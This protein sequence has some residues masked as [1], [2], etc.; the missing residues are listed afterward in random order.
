[1][2]LNGLLASLGS[3]GVT[4]ATKNRY[5]ESAYL[6]T[7]KTEPNSKRSYKIYQRLFSSYMEKKDVENGEKTLM[8]FKRNFPRDHKTQEAMLAQIMEYYKQNNDEDMIKNYVQRIGRGEFK[9]SKNYAKKLNMLLLTMQFDDVEKLNSTG[10]KK[11]ALIGYVEIYK[12][13]R[14]SNEARK[15]AAYNIATL[16]YQLGDAER[17]YKWAI[18]SLNL[19]S[20]RDVSRFESSFLAMA[21]DVFGKRRFNE[22]ADL[23]SRLLGKVCKRRSRNKKNFFKN[24]HVIYLASGNLKQAKRIVDKGKS[25]RIPASFIREG[26]IDLIKYMASNKNWGQL[27]NRIK[28]VRNDSRIVPEIIYPM[29]LLAESLKAS[30]RLEDGRAIESEIIKFYNKSKKRKKG[31]PLEGLDVVA[32]M[33]LR[34]LRSEVTKLKSIKLTFPEKLY[35]D[36]LKKIF[37]Q[38]DR[39]TSEALKILEVGSGR[40]I[41]A[42]Y[43]SLV[44]SYEGVV[45]QIREFTP[46]GKSDRYIKSFKKSM[47]DLTKPILVKSKDFRR[48]A[49][50]QVTRSNILSLDNSYFLQSKQLPLLPEHYFSRGAVLMDRGGRR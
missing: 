42:A 25:C 3:K 30:G 41:V 44:E 11:Q 26:Q 33:K 6:A 36:S 40:G 1:M 46:P 20:N 38:L 2:A 12:S 8:A 18:E 14:S 32:D 10:E 24:A 34:T 31:I 23:N 49:I 47:V 37:T 17:T 22:A 21:T 29:S 43:R 28:K 5:L 16:F 45:S 9:V 13:P 15:N 19:M 48:E 35:N 27:Q 7:V 4:E 50:G 39:V